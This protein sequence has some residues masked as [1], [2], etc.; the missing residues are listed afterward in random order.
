MCSFRNCCSSSLAGGFPLLVISAAAA[1][2]FCFCVF[3]HVKLLPLDFI[4][5][6]VWMLSL[7]TSSHYAS[8]KLGLKV[9]ESVPE[10]QAGSR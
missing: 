4:F 5:V 2:A 9:K 8:L 3:L 7:F 10:V 1:V 6:L